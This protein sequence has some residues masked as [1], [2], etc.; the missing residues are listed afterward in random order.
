MRAFCHMRLNTTDRIDRTH[1]NTGA[2]FRSQTGLFAQQRRESGRCGL[3]L[4]AALPYLNRH[5]RATADDGTCR[6]VHSARVPSRSNSLS[7]SPPTGL[8]NEKLIFQIRPSP[9]HRCRELYR[10]ATGMPTNTALGRIRR[11]CGDPRP[12][13]CPTRPKPN[14]GRHHFSS[15]VIEIAPLHAIQC[16]TADSGMCARSFGPMVP[17]LQILRMIAT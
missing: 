9:V 10:Y 7:P 12:Q 8:V 3:L 1:R 16:A 6:C 15:A 14:A 2:H 11:R 4:C 17:H 5:S 13:A